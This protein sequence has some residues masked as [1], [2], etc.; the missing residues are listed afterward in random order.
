M[1]IAD[2]PSPN[3]CRTGL[4]MGYEVSASRSDG[5][6]DALATIVHLA[7][8]VRLAGLVRPELLA[9]PVQRELQRRPEMMRQ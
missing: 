2:H 1:G 5:I 3:D 4:G 6:A 9:L 8:L 7:V